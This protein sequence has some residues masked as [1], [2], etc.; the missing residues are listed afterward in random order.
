MWSVRV[1]R[2]RLFRLSSVSS[3]E[4]IHSC[5]WEQPPQTSSSLSSVNARG[6]PYIIVI[7]PRE[8]NLKLERAELAC[9]RASLLLYLFWCERQIWLKNCGDGPVLLWRHLKLGRE[10]SIGYVHFLGER[11]TLEGVAGAFQ[12]IARILIRISCW[13]SALSWVVQI[14]PSHS[15]IALKLVIIGVVCWHYQRLFCC[16]AHIHT[17]DREVL[18]EFDWL[19]VPTVARESRAG[20]AC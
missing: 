1:E 8:G 12:A 18:R 16:R 4:A 6:L 13:H 20:L 11:E 9:A 19:P 5:L 2:T 10:A 3:Y 14:S 7:S 17:L 15:Y